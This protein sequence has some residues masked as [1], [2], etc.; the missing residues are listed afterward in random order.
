MLDVARFY[1]ERFITPKNTNLT[2]ITIVGPQV[3]DGLPFDVGGRGWLAGEK[4]ARAGNKELD[5]YQDFVGLPVGRTFDELHLLHACRWQDVVGETIALIRFNYEDGTKSELPIRYG[6]HVRDWQRMPSESAEDMQDI[7]TK[8][9]WRCPIPKPNLKSTVRM[10]KTRLL[11]PFPAKKVLSLDA[12]STRHLA[13]YDLVAAT[14]ANRD[15]SRPESPAVPAS[16]PAHHFGSA[17]VIRVLDQATGKPIS[18]ALVDPSM[19]VDDVRVVATPLYT[20]TNGEAVLPY[21]RMKMTYLG[22]QIQKQGY[23][24]QYANWQAKSFGSNVW[25]TAV[26]QMYLLK[27]YIPATNTVSMVPLGTS[28]QNV[29]FA[30]RLK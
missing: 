3:F 23:A 6:V 9:I 10:F 20:S 18:G 28:P 7:N 5:H 2:F 26:E 16:V 13:A 1:K 8:V 12:V 22:A 25:Q 27:G 15:P 17:V 29:P 4:E 30:P 24:P 21:P 11:N 19:I 14:V